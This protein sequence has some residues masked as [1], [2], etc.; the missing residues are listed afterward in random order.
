MHHSVTLYDGV[1]S[2]AIVISYSNNPRNFPRIKELVFDA[3]AIAWYL[4]RK[5]QHLRL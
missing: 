5:M 1:T 4:Q 3:N 2:L